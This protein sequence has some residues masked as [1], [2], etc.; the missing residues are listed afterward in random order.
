MHSGIKCKQVLS[1][2]KNQT[3]RV[4]KWKKAEDLWAW[5]SNKEL[6]TAVKLSKS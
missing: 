3:R 4:I 6:N 1:K 2:A 5:Q